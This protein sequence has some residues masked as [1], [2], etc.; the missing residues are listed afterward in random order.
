MLW[1]TTEIAIH[2]SSEEFF[3]ELAR[4]A[5]IVVVADNPDPKERF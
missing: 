3:Q 4:A 5:L 2:G 1:S